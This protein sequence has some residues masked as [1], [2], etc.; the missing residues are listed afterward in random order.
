MR[1][2]SSLLLA[3]QVKPHCSF[4]MHGENLPQM[5]A[6]DQCFVGGRYAS[7]ILR[8]GGDTA[9]TCQWH[10]DREDVWKSLN[11]ILHTHNVNAC[12]SEVWWE[13]GRLLGEN[14]IEARCEMLGE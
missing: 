1:S 6:A 10:F 2:K 12:F 4:S 14:Q 5:Y 9:G 11:G 7:G 13:I 3:C 8:G